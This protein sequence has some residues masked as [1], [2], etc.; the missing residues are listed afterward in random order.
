MQSPL[1]FERSIC[2]GSCIHMPKKNLSVFHSPDQHSAKRSNHRRTTQLRIYP[3]IVNMNIVPCHDHFQ[4]G[5]KKAPQY[6][7]YHS[8]PKSVGN[9]SLFWCMVKTGG[10]GVAEGGCYFLLFSATFCYFLLFS[11]IL[12]VW[13]FFIFWPWFGLLLKGGEMRDS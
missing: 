12:G 7:L 8:P 2:L 10:P 11:A 4:P 3:S 6:R 5:D 13:I 1:F 9:I